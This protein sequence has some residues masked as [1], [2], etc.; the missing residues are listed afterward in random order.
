MPQVLL[1]PEKS[2]P[3]ENKEQ[4][5]LE[6][7]AAVDAWAIGIVCFELMVGHPPFEK[8]SQSQTYEHIMYRA[9]VMPSVLSEG[10]K[11]FI[12]SALVK[13]RNCIFAIL[14]GLH[15]FRHIWHEA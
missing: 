1:C 4:V 3:E 2:R 13:V 8:K 14:Q 15:V 7:T 5:V 10:A 6:Y 9:P 11:Q 12:T